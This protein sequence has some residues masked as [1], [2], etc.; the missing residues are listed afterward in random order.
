MNSEKE[1]IIDQINIVIELIKKRLSR[2][3]EKPILNTI[4]VR[5][6]DAKQI[7]IDDG[8]INKITIFGGCRAYLDAYNDY[9]NPMLNE[10]YKAEKKL[11]KLRNK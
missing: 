5:Y 9:M 7:L 4:Y 11:D 8:D 2:G 1:E 3:L 6:L 10:M